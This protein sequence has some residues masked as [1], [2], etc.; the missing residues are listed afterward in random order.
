MY[1][2]TRVIAEN[3]G[4]LVQPLLRVAGSDISHWFEA[5][6]T[7]ATTPETVELKTYVDPVTNLVRP[8]CPNGRFVH[9]P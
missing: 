8:Y 5:R 4:P 1:D 7:K 2:I 3:E 6:A 9:V